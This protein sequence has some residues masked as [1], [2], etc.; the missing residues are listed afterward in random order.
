M[1]SQCYF[2]NVKFLAFWDFWESSLLKQSFLKL[3]SDRFTFLNDED[4]TSDSKVIELLQDGSR[5]LDP[6]CKTYAF[7][8]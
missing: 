8:F 7:A 6:S 5:I 2:R 4:R 1:V 3:N